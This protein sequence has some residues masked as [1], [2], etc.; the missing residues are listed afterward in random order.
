MKIQPT[1]RAGFT[2]VEIMVVVGIIGVLAPI[3]IPNYMKARTAAHTNTCI[4]NIRAI[5]TAK[6]EW[7]TETLQGPAAVPASEDLEPYLGRGDGSLERAYCPLDPDKTIDT[8]YDLGNVLVAP[9][10]NFN[11]DDHVLL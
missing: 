9:K 11:P 5:D 6:Q 2:L 7:A 10:C 8:S 3:A 4:N 1:R